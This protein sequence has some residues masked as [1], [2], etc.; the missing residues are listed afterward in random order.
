MHVGKDRQRPAEFV[1]TWSHDW[2]RFHIAPWYGGVRTH[3]HPSFLHSRKHLIGRH[4]CTAIIDHL[5]A[6]WKKRAFGKP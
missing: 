2:F 5:D 4:D 1:Y 3:V 6:T